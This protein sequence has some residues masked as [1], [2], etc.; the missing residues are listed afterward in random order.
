[1][2][3]SM[4]ANDQNNTFFV[5]TSGLDPFLAF[6]SGQD[7]VLFRVFGNATAH[8]DRVGDDL[9]IS[10]TN[11]TMT[12]VKDFFVTEG[13]PRHEIVLHDGRRVG[14]K[15]LF[16]LMNS[17]IVPATVSRAKLPAPQKN[18]RAGLSAEHAKTRQ[19]SDKTAGES[20]KP[21]KVIVGSSASKAATEP[22]KRLKKTY[23]LAPSAVSASVIS[24]NKSDF[25]I[26]GA[27]A[28]GNSV[29][30]GRI[31]VA[32]V[33]AGVILSYSAD[34]SSVVVYLET[35]KGIVAIGNYRVTA[36][37]EIYIDLFNLDGAERDTLTGF[38]NSLAEGKSYHLSDVAAAVSHDGVTVFANAE[39]MVE[40][41]MRVRASAS[42][43]N[44]RVVD[45]SWYTVR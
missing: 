16:D 6:E 37:G 9:E 45:E 11:G 15:E 44:H 19:T 2:S 41:S 17:S 42:E 21:V 35:P 40:G 1:M 3:F 8:A 33:P 27:F 26:G 29:F 31:N 43:S 23:V 30:V 7:D 32:D 28:S 18:G 20:R 36:V 4:G 34:E 38:V 12:Q 22:S 39:T 5:S 10:F 13:A 24:L 25:T 14:V